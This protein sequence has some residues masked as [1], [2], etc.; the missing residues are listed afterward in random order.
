MTTDKIQQCQLEGHPD[1]WFDYS[2]LNGHLLESSDETK[3]AISICNRCDARE[4]CLEFAVQYSD[5]AGIWGGKTPAERTTMR[6]QRNILPIPF[7]ETWRRP[8]QEWIDPV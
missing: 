7:N 8:T 4:D 6:K 1:W 5:L 2:E 3:M